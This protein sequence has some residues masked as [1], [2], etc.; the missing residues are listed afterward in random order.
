MSTRKYTQDDL[1]ILD[2]P[3]EFI[4]R[5]RDLFLP[6]GEL[7][8]DT[9]STTLAADVACISAHPVAILQ[10]QGW[11]VVAGEEDWIE[12]SVRRWNESSQKVRSI[13]EFFKHIVPFPERGVHCHHQ[14]VIIMAFAS[15][16]ATAT[17]AGSSACL[18]GAA[19]H[20][21]LSISV[22]NSLP[23]WKRFVAFRLSGIVGK[24]M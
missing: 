15:S 9:L 8:E 12:V 21:D 18:L 3:L 22:T 13:E 6:F 11:W 24:S 14:E 17:A 10:H 5:H 2:S 1:Q 16:I 19:P 20:A 23:H 4:R 7:R